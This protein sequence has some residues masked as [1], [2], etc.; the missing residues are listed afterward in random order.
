MFLREAAKI[1]L[2]ASTQPSADKAVVK[3]EEKY[4]NHTV[5]SICPNLS[6]LDSF[7]RIIETYGCIDILVNNAGTTNAAPFSDYSRNYL[8]R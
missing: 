8:R 1:I 2:C 4:P 7:Q 5:D 6:N 3:L